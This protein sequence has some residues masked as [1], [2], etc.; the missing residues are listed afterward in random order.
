MS[1][2]Q[3]I[4]DDTASFGQLTSKIGLGCAICIA[5][6]LIGCI[7]YLVA[8]QNINLASTV[9]TITKAICTPQTNVSGKTTTVTYNCALTV[10][11]TIDNIKYEHIV[12]TTD[13]Q[14]NINDTIE[15]SYDKTN[16]NTVQEK[17]MNV[18]TLSGILSC[19]ATS[20][21]LCAYLNYYLTNTSKTYA[22]AQGISSAFSIV[23]SPFDRN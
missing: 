7:I 19:I 10:E 15:L 8:T 12:N 17:P 4:Y 18:Y 23:T 20:L 21:V 3:S 13:K 14:Y 9:G 16:P 1:L 6:I 11:Y 5:V 2:G 22:A